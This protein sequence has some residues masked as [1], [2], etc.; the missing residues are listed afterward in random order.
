M[1]E[2][3]NLFY[4]LSFP[5]F[6]EGKHWGKKSLK[7]PPESLDVSCDS[8]VGENLSKDCKEKQISKV[9]IPRDTG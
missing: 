1:K 8:S 5:Q 2:Q 7:A 6:E 3:T 4:L 9:Q